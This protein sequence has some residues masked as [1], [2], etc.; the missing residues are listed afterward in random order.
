MF[1]VTANSDTEAAALLPP[2]GWRHRV[3]FKIRMK[4][5]RNT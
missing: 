1:S 3:T 2:G 4:H 5:Q